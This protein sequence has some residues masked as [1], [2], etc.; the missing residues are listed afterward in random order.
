MDLATR[1]ATPPIKIWPCKFRAWLE[2]L[3][4]VTS[5]AVVAAMSNREWSDE[6]LLNE[7]AADGLGVGLST[8]RSHRLGKCKG[9]SRS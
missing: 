4:T 9:C 1:L 5:D 2:A 7:L 6:V 8:I 3:D